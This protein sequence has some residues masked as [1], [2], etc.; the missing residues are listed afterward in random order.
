M[1]CSFSRDIRSLTFEPAINREEKTKTGKALDKRGSCALLFYRRECDL[2]VIF[3]DDF[4]SIVRQS[5][6]ML[7]SDGV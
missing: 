5:L 4:R 2:T 7:F 3:V 6:D 1:I